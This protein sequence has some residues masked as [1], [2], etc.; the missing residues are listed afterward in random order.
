MDLRALQSFVVLSETLNFHAAAERLHVTQPALT[1]RVQRLE[2][3]LGLLLFE[4]SRRA[5][6]LTPEG[7]RLLPQVRR[8]LREAAE[9]EKL[10]RA[11]AAGAT[12]SLRIGYTP[13]SFFSYPP[14]LIRAF[15]RRHPEVGLQLFEMLSHDVEE[16]LLRR[17]LD[18]GFLHPPLVNPGLTSQRL[19]AEPFIAV[20][21]KDHALAARKRLRLA[22][23]ALEDFIMVRR[24]IG[25]AIYDQMIAHC[26]DAG[27]APRIRE[28]ASTSLSVVALVSAGLGVGLVIEP[29]ARLR[30]PGVCYRPLAGARPSLPFALARRAGPAS[31][32]VGRFQALVRDRRA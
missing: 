22:D 19:R 26:R 32:L 12:G 27:F 1:T 28:E 25:P 5:V 4:R 21:P 30:R 24:E 8:L 13:V 3:D 23:L 20:L 16:A 18:L 29:M 14:D 17:D 10:A 6:A 2:R 7:A 9:T 31:G 15:S 11:I